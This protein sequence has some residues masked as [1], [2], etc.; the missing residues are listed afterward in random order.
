MQFRWHCTPST[1]D[2]QLLEPSDY[3]TE[4]RMQVTMIQPNSI[5][6]KAIMLRWVHSLIVRLLTGKSQESQRVE[7]PSSITMEKKLPVLI[8]L[9]LLCA[10]SGHGL[11]ILHD[12]DGEY[13]QG[14]VFS[15][16]A[17]AET[18][19]LDPSL[20]DYENEINHVEFEPETGTSYSAAAAAPAPGPAAGSAAGSGSMKW[21]LPPS[22]IPSFP[23][24]P[25]PG[26]PGLGMPLPGIPFKPIGWGAPAPPAGA[27]G[28][29]EPSAASQVIN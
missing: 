4:M 24:F 18:E 21:W 26:M 8:Y 10:G 13:G 12:V 27:D 15:S 28:D 22:T 20:D 6:A 2:S 23:L 9:I 19:P 25:N 16:K 29:M 1:C 17:A 11:R 7:P 14:F 3:H 5:A